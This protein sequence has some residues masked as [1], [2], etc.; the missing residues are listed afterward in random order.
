MEQITHTA[1]MMTT[2]DMFLVVCSVVVLGVGIYLIFTLRRVSHITKV[3]DDIATVIEN[4]TKS[5]NILEKI[6]L[7]SVQ[8]MVEK[9]PK[10]SKKKKK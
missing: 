9:L 10:G 1:T 2:M 4:L 5:L 3:V 6:P 7:D 8:K